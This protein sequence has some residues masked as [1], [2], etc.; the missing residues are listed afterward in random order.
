[1]AFPHSINDL[2]E[3]NHILTSLP[4]SRLKSLDVSSQPKTHPQHSK[5]HPTDRISGI[6]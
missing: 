5:D 2:D 1:L 6:Y 3:T 4:A